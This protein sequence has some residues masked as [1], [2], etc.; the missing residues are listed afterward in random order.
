M[1]LLQFY[2]SE[3]TRDLIKAGPACARGTDP[4]GTAQHQLAGAESEAIEPA[5]H[6]VPKE[7]RYSAVLIRICSVWAIDLSRLYHL[8]S[9]RGTTIDLL[10]LSTPQN[11]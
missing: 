9:N 11:G 1:E 5:G 2:Y 3:F 6:P 10:R 7:P 8:A 4:R